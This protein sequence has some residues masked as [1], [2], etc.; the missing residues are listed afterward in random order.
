MRP[1]NCFTDDILAAIKKEK[2]LG[3]RAGTD[4]NHR[5]IEVWAV[6]GE[7]RVFVRS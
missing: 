5:I 2:I 4:S 1:R 6:V 3:I 7:G